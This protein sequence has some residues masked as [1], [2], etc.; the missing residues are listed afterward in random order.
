MGEELKFELFRPGARGGIW[1][2]LYYILLADR[3]S[4]DRQVDV[5]ATHLP[6]T[7]NTPMPIEI[8]SAVCS[9]PG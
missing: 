6:F 4:I 2:I 7:P 3:F 1:S 9:D 5:M 8:G